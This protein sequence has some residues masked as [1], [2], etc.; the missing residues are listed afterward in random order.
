MGLHLSRP[1][2]GNTRQNHVP[3]NT[4]KIRW[5]WITRFVE[6]E[7]TQP[8]PGWSNTTAKPPRGPHRHWCTRLNV[9]RNQDPRGLA[10]PPCVAQSEDR[11][12]MRTT[13][14]DHRVLL[15]S[16]LSGDC[17]AQSPG[18]SVSTGSN[19]E[20]RRSGAANNSLPPFSNSSTT[21]ADSPFA[22]VSS[23]S[24]EP[25]RRAL[26]DDFSSR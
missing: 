26:L 22:P 21:F 15:P 7:F 18:A 8:S 2:P 1:D 17:T 23:P 25:L 20:A 4:P 13:R 12:I 16:A 24:I 19:D 6:F 9:P 3:N 5:N 10:R 14:A 11:A